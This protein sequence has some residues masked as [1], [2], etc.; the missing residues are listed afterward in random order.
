[1]REAV[2]KVL[3][4]VRQAL[5]LHAG[6]IELVEILEATGVVKVRLTGTCHGCALS[7]ITLKTGVET[8]LCQAIPEVRQVIAV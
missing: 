4:S 7:D 2:E 5:K 3:E 8:A 1:M 6:G